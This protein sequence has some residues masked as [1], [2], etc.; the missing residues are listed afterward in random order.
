MSEWPITYAGLVAPPLDQALG[1]QPVDGRAGPLG[2][3]GR[4]LRTHLGVVLATRADD[5]NRLLPAVRKVLQAHLTGPADEPAPGRVP[6]VDPA[7]GPG[8]KLPA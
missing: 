8:H 4:R 2:E 3:P 6:A 1:L 7:A 5:R